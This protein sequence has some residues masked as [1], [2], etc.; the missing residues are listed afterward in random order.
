MLHT[1]RHERGKV[2]A[3][4]RL[5]LAV[6]IVLFSVQASELLAAVVPDD[7]VEDVRGTDEDPCPD[8][9]A[10]CVCCAG[11]PVSVTPP[12]GR[13]PAEAM[14]AT[15]TGLPGD[16]FVSHDPHGILHVPKTR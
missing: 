12:P 8:N 2:D 4:A 11:L 14:V 1:L 13:V 15:A 3:V 6:W 9:C 10:R 7:C 16:F 5:F